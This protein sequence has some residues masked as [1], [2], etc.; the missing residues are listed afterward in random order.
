[1]NRPPTA[2]TE[3][4]IAL[5]RDGDRWLVGERGSDC[6]LAGA[7]EFPG[8]K[9]LPPESLEECAIRE[10]LE[11]TGLEIRIDRRRCE[12]EYDYPHGRFRLTFFDCSLVKTGSPGGGFRWRTIQELKDLPFP[13]ANRGIVESLQDERGGA[14]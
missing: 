9:R 2:E 3:I 12:V 4:A 6:P 7:A 1:M 14:F 8:G 5:I 11:E 10:C 13:A